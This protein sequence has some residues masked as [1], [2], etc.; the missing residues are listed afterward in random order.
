MNICIPQMILN[1]PK[2]AREVGRSPYLVR[3][4]ELVLF[5]NSENSF[6]LFPCQTTRAPCRITPLTLAIILKF[7]SPPL[8]C[9]QWDVTTSTCP[10]SWK[11]IFNK[12][13]NTL[14]QISPVRHNIKE[15]MPTSLVN[16]LTTNHK[17]IK[18]NRSQGGRKISVTLLTVVGHCWKNQH[19]YI[20]SSLYD[21]AGGSACRRGPRDLHCISPLISLW[22]PH[23]TSVFT[24]AAVWLVF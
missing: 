15:W 7:M 3:R 19:I 24:R 14:S 21:L 18:G 16:S 1:H 13:D 6:V 2:T 9:P 11:T 12:S 8:R 4:A 10:R 20:V 23:P 17:L 5:I 22:R